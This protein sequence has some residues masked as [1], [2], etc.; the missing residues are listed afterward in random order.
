M[1]ELSSTPTAPGE[2][3]R[4]I[5]LAGAMEPN[6]V[7]VVESG[8]SQLAGGKWVV[9][10]SG[11]KTR[12]LLTRADVPSG[13]DQD[14]TYVDASVS[15]PFGGDVD[16]PTLRLYDGADVIAKL[17]SGAG[18]LLVLS[19]GLAGIAA[20]FVLWFAFCAESG[21]S[22]KDVGANGAKLVAWAQ[23]PGQQHD[24]AACLRGDKDAPPSVDGVACTKDEPSFLRNKG[25]AGAFAAVFGLASVLL[26]GWGAY[27]QFG[28]GK[29]P[30]GT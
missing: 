4:L 20:L 21:P 27:R 19:T 23:N 10:T 22:A 24:A 12:E 15:A 30:G 11:G 7:A 1:T 8:A 18:L 13:A 16:Q 5:G 2:L 26:T 17:R 28:P 25:N 14:G 6:E 29:T 3:P 9:L